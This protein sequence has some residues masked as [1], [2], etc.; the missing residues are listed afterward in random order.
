MQLSWSAVFGWLFMNNYIWAEI[1]EGPVLRSILVLALVVA[2][3]A[4]QWTAVA[5]LA[6][7]VFAWSF[8]VWIDRLHPAREPDPTGAEL[9]EMLEAHKDDVAKDLENLRGKL[10]MRAPSRPGARS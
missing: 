3:I 6:V 2:A 5:C 7:L 1:V 10:E 8:K 4:G 9:R